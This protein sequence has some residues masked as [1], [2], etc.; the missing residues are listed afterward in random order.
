ME[1]L[2][3]TLDKINAVIFKI[4]K[5]IFIIVVAFVVVIDTAQVFGRYVF[6]FSIPWSDQVSLLI[7]CIIIM[8]GGNIAIK[9]NAEVKVT[10]IHFKDEKKQLVFDLVGDVVSMFTISF[11]VASTWLLIMQASTFKKVISSIQLDYKYV[12]L[13]VLL[14][15]VIMLFEKVIQFL[16]RISRLGAGESALKKEGGA[17]A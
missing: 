9:D 6:K 2:I 3:S 12:Y 17:K 7:F 8:L 13:I 4:Q 10:L 11:F 16:K 1:K 14:G 15:F 5:M